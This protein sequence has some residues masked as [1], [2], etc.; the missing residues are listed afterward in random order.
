MRGEWQMADLTRTVSSLTDGRAWSR[1]VEETQLT[2]GLYTQHNE[3]QR[4]LWRNRLC[5][6]I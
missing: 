2:P 3:T 5:S 1:N 4:T 6:T